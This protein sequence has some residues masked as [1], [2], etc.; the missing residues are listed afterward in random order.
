MNREHAT[1]NA[2]RAA[3]QCGKEVVV[4]NAPVEHAHDADGPYGFCESQ[5]KCMLFPKATIVAT[6]SPNGKVSQR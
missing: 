4:V 2:K 1:E 6:I 3:L 5:F